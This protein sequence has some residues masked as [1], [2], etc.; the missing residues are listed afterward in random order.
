MGDGLAG[1]RRL[2]WVGRHGLGQRELMIVFRKA[3]GR[4]IPTSISASNMPMPPPSIPVVSRPSTVPPDW[5]SVAPP[6][7]SRHI[8]HPSPLVPPSSRR[9]RSATPSVVTYNTASILATPIY[10]DG[11]YEYWRPTP[12]QYDMTGLMPP[13]PVRVGYGPADTM[14]VRYVLGAGVYVPPGS[15][16]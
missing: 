8:Y 12:T 1:W 5:P 15:G 4:V 13:P 2:S 10:N 6:E 9:Y 16:E 3:N 14:D 7:D 11:T